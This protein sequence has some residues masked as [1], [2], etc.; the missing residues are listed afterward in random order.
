MVQCFGHI[1]GG[2]I[3]PA[4]TAAMLPGQGPVLLSGGGGR[5][6]ILFLVTPADIRGDL[7][8]NTVNPKLSVGHGLVVE[9]I[10]TFQ[11]VFTIFATGDTKR[12][13]LGG[14]ASLMNPARSLGPALVTL[15]FRDLWVY[16]VGP[17][18]GAVLA[19]GTYEYLYCPD[20]AAKRCRLLDVPP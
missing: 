16:W 8:V 20:P 7:G 6:G 1:S 9:L 2:H 17:V 13:D 11:L 15:N 18:L 12:N 14:S 5:A 10:I 3:N 19:A 4:V